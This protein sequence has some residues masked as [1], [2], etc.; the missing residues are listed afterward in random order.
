M[1]YEVSLVVRV[2]GSVNEDAGE[3]GSAGGRDGGWASGGRIIEGW[4]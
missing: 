4:G 2:I 3:S 1:G